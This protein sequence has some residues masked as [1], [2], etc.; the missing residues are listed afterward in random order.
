MNSM[1]WCLL[2]LTVLPLPSKIALDTASGLQRGHLWWSPC[3]LR[4]SRFQDSKKVFQKQLR[5]SAIKGSSVRGRAEHEHPML[6]LFHKSLS[7]STAVNIFIT[8]AYFRLCGY[9]IESISPPFLSSASEWKPTIFRKTF[10][11][12][13]NIYYFFYF[14]YLRQELAV[15]V[16]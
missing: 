6:T 11:N 1:R 12:F 2:R 13:F 8:N 7:N 5:R 3:H 4:W 10:L 16:Q 9:I 15:G 14:L